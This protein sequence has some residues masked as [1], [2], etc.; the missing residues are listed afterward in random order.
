MDAI[1]DYVPEKSSSPTKET[2]VNAFGKALEKKITS[3]AYEKLGVHLY[4]VG[5]PDEIVREHAVYL[6]KLL[7]AEINKAQGL[8]GW[9]GLNHLVVMNNSKS[10][11]QIVGMMFRYIALQFIM[12]AMN[13]Y[14]NQS[15]NAELIYQHIP[16]YP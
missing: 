9:N 16:V 5:V 12:T 13:H 4:H 1:I 6:T 7:V 2:H 15:N 11:M 3:T 10:R 14:L 8:T